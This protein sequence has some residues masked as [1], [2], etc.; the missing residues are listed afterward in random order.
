MAE[1]LRPGRAFLTSLGFTFDLGAAGPSA[2]ANRNPGPGERAPVR[3]R[4]HLP[5]GPR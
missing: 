3:A 1:G 2:T 5:A 4:L